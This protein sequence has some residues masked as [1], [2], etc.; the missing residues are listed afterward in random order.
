MKTLLLTELYSY[1]PHRPAGYA[2]DVIS[3]GKLDGNRVMLSDEAYKQLTAKYA[4]SGEIPQ[5][6]LS[7][8]RFEICKTCD[9]VKDQAFACRLYKGCCFGQWRTQPTSQCPATPPRWLAESPPHGP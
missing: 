9:Q 2:K 8:Q 1:S 7:K 3:H 5:T 4:P 6:E